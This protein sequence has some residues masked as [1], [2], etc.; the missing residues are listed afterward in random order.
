MHESQFVVFSSVLLASL[1]GSVHC[2]AMCGG[3]TSIAAGSTPRLAI[4]RAMAYHLGRLMTYLAA[5]AGA[6]QISN[7]ISPV[8]IG[9][10]LLTSGVLLF[11]KISPIPNWLHRALT[12]LYRGVLKRTNKRSAVFPF[13]V[14]LASTLLPCGWLYMYIGIAAASTAPLL[15]MVFFWLGTLP[16]LTIWSTASGWALSVA[17]QY[18][19]SLRAVLL[20]GAGLLSIFQHNP[21]QSSEAGE[22]SCHHQSD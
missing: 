4:P 2:V 22:V 10:L 3:F 21:F 14:G 11:F 6:S 7:I 17:G 9:I 15:T 16:I 12:H 13:V 19:P 5:G 18:F 8:A 1:L 20:I